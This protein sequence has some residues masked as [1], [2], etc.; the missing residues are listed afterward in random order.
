MSRG[1]TLH[2]DILLG[3]YILYSKGFPLFHGKPSVTAL[4]PSQLSRP[5]WPKNQP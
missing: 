3:N 1:V 4:T 5:G 2:T